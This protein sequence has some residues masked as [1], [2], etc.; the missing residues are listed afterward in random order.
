[1]LKRLHIRVLTLCLMLIVA[2]AASA[3]RP[4]ITERLN[5][6]GQVTVDAPKELVKRNNSDLGKQQNN[7]KAQEKDTGAR[8]LRS[9]IEDIMLDIMYEI[10]KDDNIGRVTITREYLEGK[11][12]PLI[13]TRG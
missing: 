8:A 6:N 4:Q 10:P 13:E 12:S 3:Q 5:R 7:K 2:L 11:G 9:I 1:M